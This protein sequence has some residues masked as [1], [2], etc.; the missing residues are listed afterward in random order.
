MEQKK[1][2]ISLGEIIELTCELVDFLPVRELTVDHQDLDPALFLK[3]PFNCPNL[4]ISDQ[5]VDFLLK[6]LD[7]NRN[8][9]SWYVTSPNQFSPLVQ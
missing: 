5:L 4:I 3:I 2:L 1:L 6:S 8:R 7:L 9:I